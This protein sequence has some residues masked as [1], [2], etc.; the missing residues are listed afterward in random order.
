MKHEVDLLI[1][2]GVE[3]IRVKTII[4]GLRD[5]LDDGIFYLGYDAYIDFDRYWNYIEENIGEIVS[6]N[7]AIEIITYIKPTD[8][9]NEKLL[10]HKEKVERALEEIKKIYEELKEAAESYDLIEEDIENRVNELIPPRE[11]EI[12]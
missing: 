12:I 7:D 11:I 2:K 4:S 3:K 5:L 10:E 8:N 9:L 6:D 1:G